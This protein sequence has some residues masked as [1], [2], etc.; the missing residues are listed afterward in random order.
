[1]DK[2]EIREI[3][4]A[5]QAAGREAQKKEANFALEN[6]V[7]AALYIYP[8]IKKLIEESTEHIKNKAYTSFDNRKNAEKLPNV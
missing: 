2:R 7:K 1:M 3:I 5:S 6:Y 4:E 8:R